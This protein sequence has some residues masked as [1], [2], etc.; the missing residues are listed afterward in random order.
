[1]SQ[2]VKSNLFLYAHD[3]CIVFQ[4]K[5]VIES[6]KKLNRYFK[7][8]CEWFVDNRLSI[9]SG[10]EKTKSILFTSKRKIKKFPKLK[11][12]Y[13]NIQIKQHQRSHT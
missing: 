11:I 13:K 4:G 9:H 5:D 8:I 3:S 12:N 1:M 10:E 7:N 2:A 6:E